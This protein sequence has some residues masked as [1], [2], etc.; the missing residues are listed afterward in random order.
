MASGISSGPGSGRGEPVTPPPRTPVPAADDLSIVAPAG[1]RSAPEGVRI[2]PPATLDLAISAREAV[3]M[4]ATAVRTRPAPAK[5]TRK[6]FVY[7]FEEGSAEMRSL[8]GGKGAG[9]AEM[10]RAGMPVPPGFT[11]TTAACTAYMKAGDRFPAGLLDEVREHLA[12]L[13]R[14]TGKGLGDA[15][16]PLLVSVRSGA[17]LSMP[18]MM[19]TV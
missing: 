3:S 12:R 16:E 18:G 7:D 4:T 1:G 13:E 8:L 9:V 5:R 17:S 2:P 15:K 11:I 10:T 19:D 14:A 6:K